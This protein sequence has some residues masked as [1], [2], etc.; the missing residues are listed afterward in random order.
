MSP[1]R[2]PHL[3]TTTLWDFPSQQYGDETQ[4]SKDYAGATPAWVIWNLLQRFT[5]RGELVLDPMAGS[6][7]ALDVAR[8]LGRTARGFDVHPS[9][10]EIEQADAR[11]LPLEAKS[12]DFVFVDPPYSTHIDYGEDPR[13]IGKLDAAAPAYLEAM[14]QVIGEIA[15]VLRP[16]RHVGLYCCDSWIKGR[17]LIPIGFDLFSRLR[18]CFEPVDIV[19]VVRRNRTLLRARWHEEALAGGYL[20]RGFNYLFIMRRAM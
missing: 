19:A 4:G 17:P 12:V 5:E 18:R 6:G 8:E 14:E 13:D 7:T 20:L 1:R 10:P 9:R 16:G 15:R 11:H 2:E 3:M